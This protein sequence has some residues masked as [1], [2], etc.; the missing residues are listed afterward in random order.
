MVRDR[1]VYAVVDQSPA[2]RSKNAAIAKAKASL[3]KAVGASHGPHIK[4]D[5]RA[6]LAYYSRLA[7]EDADLLQ[8]G[9][10]DRR[11]GAWTWLPDPLRSTFPA[12]DVEQLVLSTA[13]D[14]AE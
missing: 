11:T 12:L 3:L 14:A 2:T 7:T 13:A 8:I 5:F 9:R 6:N 1:A 4:L 10:L